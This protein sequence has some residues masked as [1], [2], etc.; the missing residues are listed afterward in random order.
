M[1]IN[2]LCQKIEVG[3]LDEKQVL[4]TVSFFL[5][6]VTIKNNKYGQ[7]FFFFFFLETD[8]FILKR[9]HKFVI[10]IDKL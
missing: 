3:Y 2:F 8:N 7:F 4:S 5:Y 1:K 9:F 10:L 6:F